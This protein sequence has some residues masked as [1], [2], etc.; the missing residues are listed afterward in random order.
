MS[1]LDFAGFTGVHVLAAFLWGMNLESYDLIKRFAM[2]DPEPWSMFQ[3]PSSEPSDRRDTI[4]KYASYRLS[5][6]PVYSTKPTTNLN[7]TSN[8]DFD[9]D[10]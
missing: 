5:E 4:V 8:A 7:R 3:I 6:R 10:E 2:N 9:Y 1:T